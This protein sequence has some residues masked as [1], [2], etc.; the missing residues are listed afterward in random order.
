M[1]EIILLLFL[2]YLFEDFFFS[3]RF[4]AEE[5]VV[6]LHFTFFS[7]HAV[8]GGSTAAGGGYNYIVART[9]VGRGGNVEGVGGLQGN[10]GA[11]KLVEVTAHGQGIVDDG[12]D[13]GFGIDD[14]DG[15]YGFGVALTGLYH[16]VFGR[17][18]HGDVFDQ[19]EGDFHIFHA[20]VFDFFFDGA[21]PGNVA[22]EA[23]DRQPHQFGVE[24]FK[25]VLHGGKGHELGGTH[26]GEVGG[27][28]EQDDPLAFVVAREIDDAL[29]GFCGKLGCGVANAWHGITHLFCFFHDH[30]IY[31]LTMN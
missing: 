4:G 17:Y 2:L 9:P 22:V 10:Y 26:G 8:L 30:L 15:A 6:A 29:G 13:F 18:F 16:A 20:F 3:Q 7:F 19:G 12:A 1:Q 14:E 11:L 27:V 25:V 28:T 5:P 21:Q 23:V 24:F 31:R